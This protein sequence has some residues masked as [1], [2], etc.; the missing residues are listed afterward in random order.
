MRFFTKATPI[1]NIDSSCHN[2][3]TESSIGLVKL[4]IQASFHVNGY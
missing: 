3:E 1:S 2:K 4:V